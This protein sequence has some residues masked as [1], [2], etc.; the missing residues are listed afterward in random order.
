MDN[1]RVQQH[2]LEEMNETAKCGLII[3]SATALFL[4]SNKFNSSFFVHFETT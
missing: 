1:S 2:E 3:A 4:Q